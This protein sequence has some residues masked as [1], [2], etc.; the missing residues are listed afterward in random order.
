M[1]T[2]IVHLAG[3]QA[4]V[5]P[6]GPPGIPGPPGPAGPPGPPGYGNYINSDIRDYLQSEID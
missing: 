1:F 2:F 5:G 3:Y 6:Q 4:L